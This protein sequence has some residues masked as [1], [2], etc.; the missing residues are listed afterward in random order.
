MIFK[1]KINYVYIGLSFG[2]AFL[3]L[4]VPI[5]L[6]NSLISEDL[7]CS[8]L[9]ASNFFSPFRENQSFFWLNYF[10]FGVPR[11]ADPIVSIYFFIYYFMDLI[12]ENYFVIFIWFFSL[13]LG[14]W[15]GYRLFNLFIQNY[16][17]SFIGSIIFAF[18]GI[19]F[20]YNKALTPLIHPFILWIF[21][22]LIRSYRENKKN[23][24]IF[25]A[26]LNSQFFFASFSSFIWF[27]SSTAIALY[28]FSQYFK[29]IFSKIWKNSVFSFFK[30]QSIFFG[31]TFLLI[32][33]LTLSGLE[34][35]DHVV[36]LDW[37][38][39]GGYINY[40]NSGSL[41][42]WE[43]FYFPFLF[44][45]VFEI[46]DPTS[47]DMYIFLSYMGYIPIFF[48]LVWFYHIGLKKSLYLI[49]LLTCIV[50]AASSTDPINTILKSLPVLNLIRYSS[51]WMFLWNLIIIGMTLYALSAIINHQIS[52]K[53]VYYF[54][55]FGFFVTILILLFIFLF[56][57]DQ[58]QEKLIPWPLVPSYIANINSWNWFESLRPVFISLILCI[59]L[60][61]MS[62]KWINGKKLIIILGFVF[63]I[64]VFSIH[65]YGKRFYGKKSYSIQQS[66]FKI[67][68][69]GR[70][71][72]I[73]WYGFNLDSTYQ[74][75]AFENVRPTRDYT[76]HVLLKRAD[77]ILKLLFHKNWLNDYSWSVTNFDNQD[78]Q[79]PIIEFIKSKK[80]DLARALDIRYYFLG[81]NVLL[82]H[83]DFEKIDSDDRQYLYE[84]KKAYPRA[85]IYRDFER[86]DSLKESYEVLKNQDINLLNEAVVEMGFEEMSNYKDYRKDGEGVDLEGVSVISYKPTEV[87]LK[88]SVKEKSLLFMSDLNYSGWS[89]TVNGEEKKIYST[90][91]VGRGVFVE[92][93]ENEVV[94]RFFSKTF[95]LGAVLSVLG[96]LFILVYFIMFFVQKRKVWLNDI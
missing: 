22:F 52:L 25:S 43:I 2:I 55:L 21:Y 37:R 77:D 38:K 26:F 94:F 76:Q 5:F 46:A 78:Q 65:F 29:N 58:N 48:S 47:M 62:I 32:A 53:K 16:I 34:M 12:D 79:I 20:D 68:Q 19:M 45:L 75:Y 31:L 86:V 1:K 87:I 81:Q 49:V 15:G 71:R 44:P 59:L 90:N 84:D 27:F 60:K 72:T 24:L 50:F 42:I 96:H 83:L 54:S 9:F 7:Y 69:L 23:F 56:L 6:R 91:V 93:G 89:V 57:K 82:D 63:F 28:I 10:A 88:A 61:F 33:P 64:D 85:F 35:F 95:F 92:P 36:H 40:I 30:D 70:G 13:L 11:Y 4:S 39:S 18:T 80:L 41:N 67:P 51:T 17:L 66:F 14:F 8:Q 74:F 3:A 73:N